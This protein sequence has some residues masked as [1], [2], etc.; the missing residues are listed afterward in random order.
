M[1]GAECRYAYLFDPTR[2][3]KL[4]QG[5]TNALPPKQSSNSKPVDPAVSERHYTDQL[6]IESNAVGTATLNASMLPLQKGW[7]MRHICAE[8]LAYFVREQEPKGN[9]LLADSFNSHHTLGQATA[10]LGCM[11]GTIKPGP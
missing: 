8:Q 11:T 5:P 6:A 3:G 4:N 10:E 9:I 7:I 1:S 2:L